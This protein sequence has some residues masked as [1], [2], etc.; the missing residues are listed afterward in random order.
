MVSYIERQVKMLIE[1][2]TKRKAVCFISEALCGMYEAIMN[3]RSYIHVSDHLFG[4]D[5]P[6]DPPVSAFVETK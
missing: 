4:N 6:K 5:D 3:H 1:R 2:K